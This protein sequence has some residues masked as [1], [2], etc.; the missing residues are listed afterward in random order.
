M[1]IFCCSYFVSAF[2]LAVYCKRVLPA[3]QIDCKNINGSV[4]MFIQASNV[5]ISH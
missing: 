2:T 5:A 3:L 1:G 4:F